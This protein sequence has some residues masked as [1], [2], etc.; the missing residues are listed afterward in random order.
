[1]LIVFEKREKKPLNFFGWCLMVRFKCVKKV[2]IFVFLCCSST[3]CIRLHTHTHAF[4]VVP[5]QVKT[6]IGPLVCCVVVQMSV[7]M[8][9]LL[10]TCW[11]DVCWN[12]ADCCCW[13]AKPYTHKY[14][15]FDTHCVQKYSWC[16]YMKSHTI[17]SFHILIASDC[18]CI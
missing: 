4:Y 8:L 1:M 3:C 11:P 14:H 10:V 6:I 9:L 18:A 12:D 2:H 13:C 16:C 5:H 7:A 15:P 17:F